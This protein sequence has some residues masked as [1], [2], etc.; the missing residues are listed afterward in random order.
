MSYTNGLDK[1]SD[2][3][4]TV[5]YTG[6]GSSQAITGVGHQPDLSWFKTRSDA[7]G[8]TLIDSV[9][10][11]TKRLASHNTQGDITQADMLTSFDTDGFTLGA[12][13]NNYTNWSGKTWVAWNWKASGSTASNTDGSITS[14]VSANQTAGFSIVSYT[15]TG[16]NATVGHGLGA[17]PKW[18]I[19]KSRSAATRWDVYH[20]SIGATK[21]MRLNTTDA[22]R[23]SSSVFNNTEPTSSVFSLGNGAAVNASSETFIAYCFAEKKGYSKFGSYTGNG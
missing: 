6:T 7:N 16:A 4:N 20:A 13:S 15:G 1:P 9:R 19:C 2:Y 11:L 3:F 14:T 22:E 10:G 23:T 12:D 21:H 17:V 8:H 18:I 5:L